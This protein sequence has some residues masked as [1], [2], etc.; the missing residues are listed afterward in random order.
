F[1]VLVVLSVIFVGVL[2]WYNLA[3]QLT[4]EQLER[5]LALWKEKGPADYDMEYVEKG[6]VSGT[7]KVQVR[8]GKVVSAI[9]DGQ[10]MEE[11]LYRYQDMRGLFQWIDDFLR[12]DAQNRQRTFTKA[13]FD[14]D[15]GHLVHYVRRVMGSPQR[16]EIVVT[17]HP[18]SAE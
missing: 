10:P 3:Q 2:V 12:E 11:R 13:T 15:D 17:L 9:R 16:V 18:I 4:P 8:R 7:F 6:N 14:P 1:V 5:E